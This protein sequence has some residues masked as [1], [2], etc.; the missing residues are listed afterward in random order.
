LCGELGKEDVVPTNIVLVLQER[1]ILKGDAAVV[2]LNLV[3][4]T[5]N[6]AKQN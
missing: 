4:P 6:L 2:E 1:M 3:K 5:L